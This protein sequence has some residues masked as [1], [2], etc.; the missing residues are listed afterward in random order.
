MLLPLT[1]RPNISHKIKNHSAV[2]QTGQWYD[3]QVICDGAHIEVWWG[4]Q[5]SAL[6]KILSTDSA[7]VLEGTYI[8]FYA[9]TYTMLHLDNIVVSM[10]DPD[11]V[12]FEY[13]DSNEIEHTGPCFRMR[14]P[15]G[16]DKGSAGRGTYKNAS[17]TFVRQGRQAVRALAW[18]VGT[19]RSTWSWNTSA[20]QCY[21]YGGK[22]HVYT[23][24]VMGTSSTLSWV[25]QADGQL[26]REILGT[27]NSG[28][29]F[30]WAGGRMIG[31]TNSTGTFVRSFVQQPFWDMGGTLA[32]AP[33]SNPASAS[34]RYFEPDEHGTPRVLRDQNKAMLAKFEYMPYGELLS[35]AGVSS[36]MGY[37][38]MWQSC[39]S[40]NL[41][42]SLREYDPDIARWMTRDPL[43]QENAGHLF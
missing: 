3:V 16:T 9:Q 37:T 19:C 17:R 38:G 35:T 12:E 5:G 23:A 13:N 31:E 30:H 24:T 41:H 8:Y 26:H 4:A 34:Y 14:N 33:G 32:E 36:S 6:Q 28:E 18:H 42:F 21:R 27:G 20:S 43:G 39:N 11:L 25:Y 29:L 1:G 40:G 10:A 22:P 2:S 7:T 15:A